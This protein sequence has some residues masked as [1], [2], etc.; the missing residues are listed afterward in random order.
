MMEISHQPSLCQ[1]SLDKYNK[2]HAPERIASSQTEGMMRNLAP[3]GTGIAFDSIYGELLP[4]GT[5]MIKR[6]EDSQW[7]W[8][9]D[10]RPSLL[11]HGCNLSCGR[12]SPPTPTI[13]AAGGGLFL[14]F[15]Q[16]G[17]PRNGKRGQLSTKR[18]KSRYCT[19][20]GIFFEKA[21]NATTWETQCL[22]KPSPQIQDVSKAGSHVTVKPGNHNMSRKSG[23][24]H[25]GVRHGEVNVWK[26]NRTRCRKGSLPSIW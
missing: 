12:I 3:G 24:S 14:R 5:K 23:C 11:K 13:Y 22:G 6:K 15:L 4:E 10:H 16:S 1:A 26:Q 9:T 2:P 19:R 17:R 20:I 18:P 7:V 8:R 25:T 21:Y